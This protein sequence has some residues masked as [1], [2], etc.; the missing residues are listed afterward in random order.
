MAWPDL[1][2]VAILAI[3]ALKGWKRGLVSEIGGFIEI[4][5]AFWAAFHYNGAF[6]GLATSFAKAGPG[7]AH[8]IGMIGF[9]IAIYLVLL[10]ISLA[11]GLVVKLPVLGIANNVLGIPIGIAKAAVLVWAILY[12]AL[13]FPLQSDVRDDLRRSSLVQLETQPNAQVDSAIVSTMPWFMKPFVSGFLKG[14]R[15]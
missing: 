4:V 2:I 10:A 15:V 11:L 8:I 5:L 14:H 6:D 7:S 9:A 1:V 3:G 12:V 13:F